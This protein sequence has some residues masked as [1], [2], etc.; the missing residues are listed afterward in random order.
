MNDKTTTNLAFR[1]LMFGLLFAL[2]MWALIY[3]TLWLLF[4]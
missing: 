1:G 3:I 4:W 2:P